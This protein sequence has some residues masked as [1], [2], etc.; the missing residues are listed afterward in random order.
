[1]IRL[2][3]KCRGA[4]EEVVFYEEEVIT[5]GRSSKNNLQLPDNRASRKHFLIEK[6]DKCYRVVDLGS[7]NGTLLNGKKI[8]TSVL[9]KG[10]RIVTGEATL[11]VK[12][13][14][15]PGQA[16]SATGGPA[17]AAPAVPRAKP[18]NKRVGAGGITV[19]RGPRTMP[20]GLFDYLL[21][22][23][24]LALALYSGAV[25]LKILQKK[26]VTEDIRQKSEQILNQ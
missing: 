21:V 13:V 23:V 19:R 6:A 14:S 18:A 2:I 12:E 9:Q 20:Y 5:V 16:A 7:K 22:L 25:V 1:M 4:E 24:I 10:D 3:V 15:F 11:M 26:G 8:Q 17:P